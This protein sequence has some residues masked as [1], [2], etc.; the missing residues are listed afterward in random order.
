MRTSIG[1]TIVI[2]IPTAVPLIAAITG[3]REREDA[4]RQLAADVTRSAAQGF[5]A[6]GVGVVPARSRRQVRPRR[7]ELPGAGDDHGS[8]VVIGIGLGERFEQAVEHLIGD[9]V[10]DR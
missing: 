1:S 9:R 7:E 2:P 8:H 10:P 3:L 6:C 5:E 4:Q